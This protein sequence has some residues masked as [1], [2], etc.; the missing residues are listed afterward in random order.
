MRKVF[1]YSESLGGRGIS[2]EGDGTHGSV[3]GIIFHGEDDKCAG[4][5]TVE[6]IHCNKGGVDLV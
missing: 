3:W 2:C 1:N 5:V 6:R 4:L